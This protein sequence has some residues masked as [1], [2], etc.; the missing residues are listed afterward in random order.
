VGIA[1]QLPSG[2]F[3][4]VDLDYSTLWD[5]LA[6]G[7]DAYV[8]LT[9]EMFGAGYA[10]TDALPDNL[11]KSA[12]LLKTFETFDNLAFGISAKDARVMSPS[13]RRLTQTA[14]QALEDS[15]VEYR[16]KRVGVYMSG[17]GGLE[18]EGSLNT[19]GAFSSVPSALPNRISYM[20]DLRGPSIQLDTACSSSLTGV[21]LAISALERGDCDT[22]VVG[23]AQIVRGLSEWQN[24][25][26]GGVLSPDGK[27]KPF[28]TA[29]DGF[30]RGEG[31]CAVVLK[32]LEAALRDNDHIYSVIS[33]SAINSTGSVMPLNVPSAVAQKDCIANAFARAGREI[34]AD[35][36]ELHITGTP[37]G[38]PIETNA[39]GEIFPEGTVV[40][41]IKGNI[42]HLES[43][44]F[45]ASLL[46]V[47]HIVEKGIIPPVANLSSPAP[48]IAWDTHQLRV[49]IESMELTQSSPGISVVGLSGAGIGGSTG[50]IVVESAPPPLDL[51]GT[52]I[53]GN[54]NTPVTFIVGGLSPR[55]VSSISQ[56]ILDAGISDFATL[57][58]LAATLSR[59]ARQMPWR[60]TFTLPAP[61][62]I[63]AAIMVASSLPPLA[64]I[65]SGQGPQNPAMGRGLF[66]SSPVFRSAILELDAVFSAVQGYSLLESTGLFLP[67]SSTPPT[68]VLPA[69]G[70]P[71]LVTVASIAML[72]MGLFDLLVSLG[73]APSCFAGHSAG[74][75]AIL[76]ASGAGSKA[77]ALEVAIARGLAMTPTESSSVGMAAMACDAGRAE[78]IIQQVLSSDIDP[79]EKLEISCHN[80]PSSVTLSGS[81][82][83]LDA[84]VGEARKQGLFAQRIRTMVPGHSSYMD[85]IQEDYMARM[86]DIW[87]RYPGKHVPKIPVFS[88]CT[89]ETVVA[90]FTPTYFWNN[91]R[92]AVRFDSA[93]ASILQ[94]HP[95]SVFVEISCHAVLA[96]S[97]L[98]QPGVHE[99]NVLCP[100][101]RQT[102]MPTEVEWDPEL[103]LLTTTLARLA[104]LGYNGCD[105]TP[106]YGSSAFKPGWVSHPFVERSVLPPSSHSS[107]TKSRLRAISSSPLLGHVSELTHPMLAQHVINGEPILPATG[108]IE[109]A[110]LLEAG[111][112]HLWDVDF[113]SVFSL[114]ARNTN[115]DRM[116]LEREGDS[117][118]LRSSAETSS[119]T[120]RINVFSSHFIVFKLQFIRGESMREECRTMRVLKRCFYD[121]LKP[122]AAF[123]PA[124]RNVL[125]VHGGPTEVIA[126]IQANVAPREYDYLLNPATLDSCLHVVLHPAISKQ[127]GTEGMYLPA[128]LERFVYYGAGNNKGNWFSHIH[129][130]S[131]SPVTKSYD[132]TVTNSSGAIIC[133]LGGLIVNKLVAR[134]VPVGRRL[135]L[136]WQPISVPSIAA[137]GQTTY[138]TREHQPDERAL[139]TIL[140]ALAVGVISRTLGNSDISRLHAVRFRS[141]PENSLRPRSKAQCVQSIP[142]ISS[143][144]SAFRACMRVF[145]LRQ[146]CVV[147]K[148]TPKSYDLFKDPTEQG[149][150]LESFD[151]I[152]ALH[153]L[154]VATDIRS[155]LSSV[156]S[157]LVPG[158]SLVILEIDGTSWGDKDDRTHCTMSPSAW[159]SILHEVGFVNNH[160]S[161]EPGDGGQ[162]FFFT[163]QKPSSS[164][165]TVAASRIEPAHLHRYSFGDE[166]RLQ[167]ALRALNPKDR[168]ELYITALMGR[169]GDA[170]M[171]LCATLGRELPFWSVRLAV[172]ASEIQLAE[173]AQVLPRYRD[174]YQ[175]GEPALFFRRDGS[176]CVSRATLS[177][178]PAPVP[179]SDLLSLTD[180]DKLIVEIIT[181]ES[182]PLAI[183]AFVGRVV[184][185]H[186]A[187]P[188]V[189]D[190]VAGITDHGKGSLL[191]T[192]VDSV[193]CLDAHRPRDLHVVHNPRFLLHSVAV[194]FI[195][196]CLPRRSVSLLVAVSDDT[197][198][199]IFT[200]G[201]KSLGNVKVVRWDLTT[202]KQPPRVD[203]VLTDSITSDK[204]PHLRRWVSRSGRVLVWDTLLRDSLRDD[205]LDISGAFE[206]RTN[207]MNGY[208]V[209]P[210]FSAASE[211]VTHS[212][213]FRHD[214]SYVLVGGIGGLGIDLAIWMYQRGARHLVLTSRRGIASLD[215]ERDAEALSKV[216]YLRNCADLVLRLEKCDAT[217]PS[218]TFALFQSL[219]APLAGVFQMTLVLSD[220]L[221]LNQKPDSFTVVHDSK[222]KVFELIAAAI[223]ITSLDFYVA[224]SSL[225]GLTG[226]PGQANYSSACTVL[227]GILADYPNAYSLIVPGILDAGYLVSFRLFNRIFL[228]SSPQMQDRA[229]S[230]HDGLRKLQ[231]GS[232]TFNQ[233][234]PDLNFDALH[235]GLPLPATF[236]HLLASHHP[237]ASGVRAVSQASED[238]I[239]RIVLPLLEVEKADFD[240]DLP[241]LS[242]GLDSLSATRLSSALQPFLPVSQVQLLAGVS[243]SELR[244]QLLANTSWADLHSAAMPG[245]NPQTLSLSVDT[246]VEI[247]PGGGI[248]LIVFCGGEGSLAPLLALR[249]HYSDTLWGIQVTESTPTGTF[250]GLAEFYTAKIREKRP[251]GPYRLAA[252]SQSCV[253]GVAVTKLLESAGE[254][255]QQ[256]TF[257]DQFP[258][259][260]T[261]DVTEQQIREQDIPDL[262]DEPIVSMISMLR[263]DPLYSPGDRSAQLEAAR[264]GSPKATQ[265]DIETLQMTKRLIVPLLEFIVAFYPPDVPRSSS[266]FT[267]AFTRWFSAVKAPLSV[268]VAE[269]GTIT[270]LPPTLQSSWADLGASRCLAPVDVHTIPGVGHYGILGDKLTASLLQRLGQSA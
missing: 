28:D 226:S 118:S 48:S 150:H 239:L 139:F 61:A 162:N 148:V 116:M 238:D 12:A 112:H 196:D 76:Y 169:D 19:L 251:H 245:S 180:A 193:V 143:S 213:L 197:M 54:I 228:Y 77:M 142:P 207:G 217:D 117:W 248:P 183:N 22:A 80:A 190:L 73:V 33:G 232:P 131:W 3:S 2:H 32:P 104:L 29:A 242:Y 156:Q 102:A 34:G 168:V 164:S 79:D 194:S 103:A 94:S 147:S 13:A 267:E 152:I 210:A 37:R 178:A 227:N 255:V 219:P 63:P 24:Y 5:F 208:G 140:D 84:A 9:S 1:A 163:A 123:G 158:G 39:A 221:F 256:L 270:T 87:A 224:F 11:P 229:D 113:K 18:V 181:L 195:R 243:W 70:W 185:S 206:A 191:T 71:V 64:F 31:V 233:Y 88:T 114:S 250:S 269:F 62:E 74:E 6:S 90:E 127:Y 136:I 188:S 234:I 65:F 53:A 198:S 167:S 235:A 23:A 82:S 36:V 81:A 216:T 59:R 96:S 100:M 175:R 253:V 134:A 262:L 108:F 27:T 179:Y 119:S 44:A 4:D 128:R 26:L 95:D 268:L 154:H 205:A 172:F 263:S 223:E 56:S 30:G 149:I 174:F 45:L 10:V 264:V 17:G 110:S 247:R 211:P 151:I 261:S 177:S 137:E 57:R 35:Y 231:D 260:W 16:G 43:A 52:A 215:P 173:A 225:A 212:A 15:G 153:V 75:T 141:L 161:I 8:P 133:E 120:V 7:S 187:Q 160:A 72:Q 98:A 246:I 220:A 184:M 14:F 201:L 78:T 199:E 252:Y 135:D 41:S 186:R 230:L 89:D 122:F 42:G 83:L 69:T 165:R 222:V 107:R 129:R 155:C 130:T 171:G 21:H 254:Q 105:F 93:V 138:S 46:K 257:I 237:T 51:G 67:I 86:E 203:V 101:T 241:L 106:I 97:I 189:G 265:S 126:E 209:Q 58:A 258:G 170:A 182:T 85:V 38:D 47:C 145:S 166:L 144:R 146:R 91:C 92:N 125:R 236:N 109:M 200:S 50:H 259:L 49:P 25:V 68:T 240:F 176:P 244:L 111:A 66:A 214:K 121:S 40:G 157:L 249:N 192:L 99:A 60:T 132:I 266:A 20:L 115:T 202:A 55:A 218:M 159:I 124:F 204:H